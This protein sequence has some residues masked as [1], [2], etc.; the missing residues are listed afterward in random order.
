MPNSPAV[1]IST[2]ITTPVAGTAKVFVGVEP[3]INGNIVT[4]YDTPGPPSN[5][6]WE[7]DEPRIQ[8]R[9]KGGDAYS[10]AVAYGLQQTIK[11]I[12]LGM[13]RT[14]IAST[15]YVGCWQ[16]VDISSLGSDENNRTI[17]VST[18]RLVR[19]YTT[20]NRDPIQ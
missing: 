13:N 4:L 2:L 19:E 17:L 7:R 8:V 6:R 5:P 18:Y 16:V 20:A 14:T 12:L 3:Q 11:D 10:Y 15:V 1:D 9:V